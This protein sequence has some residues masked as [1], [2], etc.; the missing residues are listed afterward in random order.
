MLI[1]CSTDLATGYPPVQ[2]RRILTSWTREDFSRDRCRSILEDEIRA[3]PVCEPFLD[4]SAVD[5]GDVTGTKWLTSGFAHERVLPWTWRLGRQRVEIRRDDIATIAAVIRAGAAAKTP[6]ELHDFLSETVDYDEIAPLLPALTAPRLD[7]GRWQSI[8]RPG[9]YRREHACLAIR[10]NTTTILVDPKGL[11]DD[12]TTNGGRYPSED[13]LPEMDGIVL[14]HGHDDHWHLPSVLRYCSGSS[15]VV[16]PRSP[17]LSL[18]SKDDLSECMRLADVPSLAP[19]WN[20]TITIG[21]IEIDVLPFY[22]EQPTRDFAFLEPDVRNWGNCYRFNTPD[23][24]AIVLAD[25]GIDPGGSMLDV[26]GDSFKKRG[27]VD[28]LFCQEGNFPEAINAG[29]A[30]HAFV[31]PFSYLEKAWR[32]KPLKSMTLGPSGI[33]EACRRSGARY[34][35]PYAHGFRG[36]GKEPRSAESKHREGTD[37]APLLPPETAYV[38]WHPGD[39]ALCEAH[40]FKGIVLAEAQRES[41]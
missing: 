3:F 41:A 6:G 15:T 37:I 36:I 16:V 26:L 1:G 20:T 19:A 22:G 40:D 11:C 21:D 4:V 25:S 32:E 24:S 34:F 38:G 31:L 17:R 9:I 10:S 39:F 5:R 18:L 12:W 28:F 13:D 8:N 35:L 23:F 7:H 27:P 33:G 2:F 29:L 14:T 30:L